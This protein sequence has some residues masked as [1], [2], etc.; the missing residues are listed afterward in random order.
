MCC[1]RCLLVL[2]P[3][4]MITERLLQ[5]IWQHQYFNRM[6]LQ[7][8]AEEPLQIIY[9][10]RW[11]GHQGPDFLEARIRIADTLWVG[12]IEL[13]LKAGSWQKHAHHT[14]RN[15][16][17]VILHVV[18]DNDDPGCAPGI[19]TLVLSDRVPGILL[20]QYKTWMDSEAFVP[21]AARAGEVG[22]LVWLAWRQRLIVERL[23]RRAAL[24][25]LALQRSQW[26]WEELCWQMLARNF[27]LPVNGEAF[28]ELACSLP[29][30]VLGRHK[31]Q[32]QVIEALLLGQAGLLEGDWDE[33][34]PGE[35]RRLY[36]FYKLKY[37]LQPIS[38]PVH[39]L[40]MRPPA[41][42]TLRLAQLAALVCRR[43]RL[44]SE[45]IHA[46]ALANL[47]AI[48]AVAASRY[49]ETHFR[50]GQPAPAQSK[51]IGTTM[52]ANLVANTIVPLL[53]THGL[54]HQC[55]AEK[56]RA[57]DWLHQLPPEVNVITRRF[58][59]LGVTNA[60]AADSQALME[61]KVCYCDKR[62]CLDCAIGNA[63]LRTNDG[64]G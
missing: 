53:F 50:L 24:A 30:K 61:L 22:E 32:L 56:A 25:E 8:S 58:M 1:F 35:L 29:L 43:G 62:R 52:A 57:I 2:S 23:V 7:T 49:W 46:E 63:L 51:I 38:Q 44:F 36:A 37:G 11:N 42:P 9:P 28:E 31:G 3:E 64:E 4:M 15:Y 41:F 13:H 5:F 12:S 54:Y 16:E 60:T 27:G 17:N 48:L 19:A 10:G 59:Q 33:D 40:R 21:C 47:T 39:F 20:Q 18:W 26:D 45:I 6:E 55:E 34:Y 14:D